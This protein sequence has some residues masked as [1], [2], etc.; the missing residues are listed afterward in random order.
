M[1]SQATK[2]ERSDLRGPFWDM[3]EGRAPLPPIS[4][5]L[6]FKLV[7]IDPAK[8]TMDAEFTVDPRFLNAGGMVQGGII[9]GMLDDTMS[10]AATAHLDAMVPTLEVKV[11]FIRPG[12]TSPL[13]GSGKVVHRGREFVFLEGSLKD[14]DD[15]LIATATATAR[16][17][18][19]S[20]LEA[21]RQGAERRSNTN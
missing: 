1:D 12:R 3:I 2:Q 14:R 17:L 11:T 9:T 15:R 6:G 5:M 13:L 19:F 10:Y 8:G 16:I 4:A 21:A 7:R 20:E 18:K